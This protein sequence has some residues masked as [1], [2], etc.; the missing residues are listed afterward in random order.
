MKYVFLKWWLL[1]CAALV[2]CVYVYSLGLFDKLWFYDLSKLSFITLVLYFIVTLYIGYNTWRVSKKSATSVDFENTIRCLPGFWFSSEAMMIFGM[3]GTVIGFILTLRP[4]FSGFTAA[5]VDIIAQM[6]SGMATSCL[7]T[8]TGLL[9]M[10][11]TRIQLI[12]LEYFINEEED[13]AS[14]NW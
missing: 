10:L 6:A 4:A 13:E 14:N 5:Q 1:L 11:L 12:S 8:L 9:T 7:A 2:S 3:M